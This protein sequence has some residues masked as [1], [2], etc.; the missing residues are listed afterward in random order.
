MYV[1]RALPREVQELL[2]GKIVF[3]KKIFIF[4]FKYIGEHVAGALRWEDLIL[5][6][7]E[8]GFTE[9]RLVTAKPY[10]VTNEDIQKAIGNKLKKNKRVFIL[11][12][13]VSL[14]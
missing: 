8:A 1:N 13:F 9:P 10:L 4:Y 11:K 2:S 3:L 14:R 7:T 12:P 6:A 5:Y